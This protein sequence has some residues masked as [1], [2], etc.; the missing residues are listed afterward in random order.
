MLYSMSLW[1]IWRVLFF[2]AWFITLLYSGCSLPD[3]S[4]IVVPRAL[5]LIF[6]KHRLLNLW[7][8]GGSAD[9]V[10]IRHHSLMRARDS[11]LLL[12][13]LSISDDRIRGLWNRHSSLLL[14]NSIFIFTDRSRII[15][16]WLFHYLCCQS[17]ASFSSLVLRLNFLFFNVPIDCSCGVK[18][19]QLLYRVCL[20][21]NST[22]GSRRLNISFVEDR[23]SLQCIWLHIIII[24]L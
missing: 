14:G 19:W 2:V 13:P 10:N 5:V 21:K 7:L 8:L 4:T 9:T 17:F 23:G 16:L 11:A 18:L 1:C 20:W 24:L 3:F 22:A 15:D 12:L 6:I